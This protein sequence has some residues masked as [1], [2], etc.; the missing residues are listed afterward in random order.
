MRKGGSGELFHSPQP[1]DR[2]GE[3][4][5]AQALL[6]GN[7]DKVSENS[8]KLCQ[9]GFRLAIQEKFFTE[10]MVSHWNRLP[11]TVLESLSLQVLIEHADVVPGHTGGFGTA[12]RIV[13]ADDLRGIFQPLQL[14]DSMKQRQNDGPE[15][16]FPKAESQ[17][18]DL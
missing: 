10:R 3:P 16:W 2:C 12:E 6:E 7:R 8:L 15:T 18:L 11:M 14:C 5:R 4:G 17:A 13:G 1:P 9:D